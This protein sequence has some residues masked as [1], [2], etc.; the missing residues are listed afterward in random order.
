MANYKG[1]FF[2]VDH[3]IDVKHKV[4]L[5]DNFT[6][7]KDNVTLSRGT[8]LDTLLETKVLNSQEVDEIKSKGTKGDRVEQLLHFI[9]KTS[10]DQYEKFLESLNKT[11]HEL[12]YMQL[13]GTVPNIYVICSCKK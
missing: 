4:T 10:S 8:L 12:V 7:L 6:Y 5:I 1:W 3:K 2:V 9:M 13:R 11:D